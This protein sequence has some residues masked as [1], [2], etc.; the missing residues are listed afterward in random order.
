MQVIEILTLLLGLVGWAMMLAES[1]RESLVWGFFSLFIFPVV[2][3]FAIMNWNRCRNGF[4]LWA[5][6]I[7]IALITRSLSG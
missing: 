2:L 7:L 3:V 1:F 5:L 6:A 4:I